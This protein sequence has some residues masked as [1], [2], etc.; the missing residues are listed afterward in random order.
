MAVLGIYSNERGEPVDSGKQP[1]EVQDFGKFP[2]GLGEFVGNIPQF[3]IGRTERWQARCNRLGLGT[4]G[5]RPIMPK[6]LPKHW[7]MPI[8]KSTVLCNLLI[9]CIFRT[10]R[11]K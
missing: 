9:L 8:H 7:Y 1:V 4:L 3:N 6:N 5:S 11:H 2:I 10:P